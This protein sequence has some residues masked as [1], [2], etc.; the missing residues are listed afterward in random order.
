MVLIWYNVYKIK[1]M[2][3]FVLYFLVA[4]STRAFAQLPTKLDSLCGKSRIVDQHGQLFQFRC[5]G[6]DY[7][8]IRDDVDGSF[9]MTSTINK[10]TKRCRIKSPA[11]C[12]NCIFFRVICG[13]IEYEY[14][15]RAR[16]WTVIGDVTNPEGTKWSNHDSP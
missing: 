14:D 8:F 13:T 2:K 5:K 7:F 1:T 9:L 11:K 3:T 16:K 12:K 4:M 6:E 15:T 10:P